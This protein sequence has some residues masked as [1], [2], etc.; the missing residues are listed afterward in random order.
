MSISVYA[1][2]S[3]VQF[4]DGVTIAGKKALRAQW[5]VASVRLTHIHNVLH[6]D[7]E[8][9]AKISI[10]KGANETAAA[11][12]HTADK[13][14]SAGFLLLEL[15]AARKHYCALAAENYNSLAHVYAGANGA[16][17]KSHGGKTVQRAHNGMCAVTLA[18]LLALAVPQHM[19]WFVDVISR[20]GEA[21]PFCDEFKLHARIQSGGQTQVSCFTY[22]TTPGFELLMHVL[23]ALVLIVT[24]AAATSFPR[25]KK[26]AP[27]SLAS[28][29]VVGAF[30]WNAEEGCAD[31]LYERG[32]SVKDV[33][34]TL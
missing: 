17:S 30:E 14:M 32:D 21:R 13:C 31:F 16:Q 7:V 34:F 11:G 33:C 4:V 8:I 2:L 29:G 20:E 19:H 22:V 12:V 27:K 3:G 23:D 28:V 1:R 6:Q 25:G 26:L 15:L 24:D 9:P 18:H 5:S 10:K